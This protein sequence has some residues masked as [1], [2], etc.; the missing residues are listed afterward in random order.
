MSARL[1]GRD[2]LR[3]F[4]LVSSMLGLLW[5]G[6]VLPGLTGTSNWG[7]DFVAYRDAAE[8]LLQ[9]GSPYVPE[10][11]EAAFEPMGQ[12]L[13]L[14][15]PPPSIAVT[16]LVALDADTGAV[17]WYL[18]KIGALA[19]AAALMPVRPT[20][21]LLA[22]G[23]SLFSYAVLRDLVMG[24][25]SI[26]ITLAL[27]AGWRWLDRP[28][29]SVA[30][31]IASSIRVT[32][33]AF[34]FWFAM[35]RAWRPLMQMMA[36]GLVIL[37]LSL[38]VVG[39][40]GYEDYLTLLRNVSDTGD[41]TQNRHLTVLALELGLAEDQLW[42]VRLAVWGLTLVVIALSTRRDAETGYMVTAA[43]SLFLAPLM[44]D[45]Y[46]TLLML[47]AAFLF[48][49]GRRWAIV[50]PLLSW[51]PP[52]FTPLVAVAALLLPFLARDREPAAVV[53]TT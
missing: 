18:L 11:L 28:A 10:S 23:L 8:R 48:E 25:V 2:Y 36:A 16:P 42:L 12:F 44:W 41:L 15:P 51:T 39:I 33:G 5:L 45:H 43:A 26:L 29:G 53:A 7:E 38:P 13:Y 52:P 14:Y 6:L 46:L 1:H 17:L 4:A 9:T 31:A 27:S 32:T 19:V 35:R 40:A 21:R 20:T 3:T 34:L 30:L 49:R 47:P 50:L 22:F 37:A 24:N